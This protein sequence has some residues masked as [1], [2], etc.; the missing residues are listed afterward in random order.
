[1]A[2]C[3]V[4]CLP[5]RERGLPPRAATAA[6]AA[7]TTATAAA[8]SQVLNRHH[9]GIHASQRVHAALARGVKARGAQVQ[10]VVVRHLDEGAPSEHSLE[11]GSEP[12]AA[13]RVKG[14]RNQEE[15]FPNM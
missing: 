7:T 3:H 10:L 2:G 15:A 1:M 14:P 9:G 13:R 12:V 4:A 6:I 8:L 5:A 11:A